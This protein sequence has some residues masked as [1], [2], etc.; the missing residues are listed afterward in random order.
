MIK[1]KIANIIANNNKI[2][3]NSAYET[4]YFAKCVYNKRNK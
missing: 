3:I 2:A 1:I 4:I